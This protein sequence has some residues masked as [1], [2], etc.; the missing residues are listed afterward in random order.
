MGL[1]KKADKKEEKKFDKDIVPSLP[2]I[3]KLPDLPRLPELPSFSLDN[4]TSSFDSSTSSD[5]LSQL[6][7]FPNNSYGNK[8]SQY[9]IKEAVAGKKEVEEV[10]ADEPVEEE[11]QVMQKPLQEKPASEDI[12]SI[13]PTFND[14]KVKE[15]EPLFIRIDKFEEGS[16]TFEEVKKQ[17]LN[18][19]KFFNDL[20]KVKEDEE[21]E[22]KLFE[23]ELKEIKG[24]IDS[25]DKNIFSKLG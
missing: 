24:K 3:P 5:R 9:S 4:S 19:E 20:K 18:V 12:R 15:V 17:V 7:S 22:I 25:I 8:F 16:Q 6:P 13:Y 10:G 2:E 14:V 1:F 11:I 21:K 23:D